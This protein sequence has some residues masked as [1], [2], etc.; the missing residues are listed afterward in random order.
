MTLP[1]TPYYHYD[2]SLLQK[3]VNEAVRAAKQYGIELHYALKANNNPTL[4]D[5]IK[6]GGMGADCVSIGE[7]TAAIEAGFSPQ[8]IVFAGVGKRDDE[9]IKALEYNIAAFNC[10]S[11]QELEVI[12]QLARNGHQTARV[13]LRINPNVNADTHHHITTG[14]NENKFG[15]HTWELPLIIEKLPTW[16]NIQLT[17]IHFHI[18]SQ[19]TKLE[20]FV[21]LCHKANEIGKFFRNN[22]ISLEH[23]D[24]G[25]GLGIDYYHPELNPVP[26]FESYLT[27]IHRTLEVEP[28]Q[29]V[30][31]EPG[32]S[33]VAQCGKLITKVLYVKHLKEKKIV[34]VD[35]GMTDLIRPALYDAHH[36]IRNLSSTDAATEI[37]DVVGP[38]CESSDKFRTGVTLPV[39]QRGDLL[40]ILSAG[41]YGEVM[42][43]NYN[44]RQKPSTAFSE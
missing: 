31:C 34:I 11:I 38:I 7:V 10:E 14:L 12:D 22:N 29:T 18:G 5:I 25:G 40:A 27:A 16:K 44:L 26:D 36:E 23:I 37:Y 42:S 21:E 28:H 3:T 32:R 6:N 24:L 30:H 19:I 33:I 1:S 17:G 13:M 4:L 20:P 8:T 15:I 9:I 43:S 2:L 35:A 39:T 41:A